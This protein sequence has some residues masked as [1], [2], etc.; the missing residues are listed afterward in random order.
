MADA[1]DLKSWDYKK[2][3]GFESR[4]RHQIDKWPLF[5]GFSSVFQK[6]AKSE[7]V[8]TVQANKV[9]AHYGSKQKTAPVK[10]WRVVQGLSNAGGY[11]R[12]IRPK[13]NTH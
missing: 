6:V 12:D 8:S 11:Y 2:S 7:I 10:R 4:H 5:M 1:Q 3:C 13:Q 9:I